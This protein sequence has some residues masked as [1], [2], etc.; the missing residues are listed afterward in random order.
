M[1]LRRMLLPS[2][3]QE[4][5]RQEREIT[6]MSKRTHAALAGALTAAGCA[7]MSALEP[8]TVPPARL[9]H[10]P[11]T[12]Q[13]E[14]VHPAR[15]PIRC[16]ERGTRTIGPARGCANHGWMVIPHP[17]T[18]PGNESYARLVCHEAGHAVDP[19]IRHRGYN[20][21]PLSQ[22]APVEEGKP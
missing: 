12:A 11:V 14:M 4:S 10:V 20:Y 13:V 2:K 19:S 5:K 16:A 1:S 21:G 6:T 9:H 7:T 15:V 3:R 22:P 18:W 17:C 8:T